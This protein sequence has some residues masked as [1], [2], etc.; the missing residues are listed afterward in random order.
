[1]L[2]NAQGQLVIEGW[3]DTLAPQVERAREAL[4]QIPPQEIAR[5]SGASLQGQR[6]HLHVLFRPFDVDLTSFVVS[7]PGGGEVVTFSQNLVLSYLQTASGAPP[8]GRWISFREL[9]DGGF[10]HRAFQS[11]AA[12]R[13]ARHWELD[14]EG[15][16]AACQALGGERLDLGEAGFALR[17]LPRIALAAIYWLGDED[18]PSRASI[19]FDANASHYMSTE[20]LAVLG[21][22]LAA[23]ILTAGQPGETDDDDVRGCC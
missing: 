16:G 11:H 10:Y 9:P 22:H 13:L 14:V 19:L 23:R 12:D 21:S 3:T 17:V 18:F 6:L 1:M 8:A 5:R 7:K 20:G 2:R 15:F 4:K